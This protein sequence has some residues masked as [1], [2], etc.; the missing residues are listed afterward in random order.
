[1]KVLDNKKEKKILTLKPIIHELLKPV[2]SDD[3]NRTEIKLGFLTHSIYVDLDLDQEEE[4][5]VE[6]AVLALSDMTSDEFYA[7]SSSDYNS[8]KNII[9][10]MITKTSKDHWLSSVAVS[11]EKIQLA[12]PIK[13]DDGHIITELT[14]KIPTVRTR[15][16][17]RQLPTAEAKQTMITCEC[18][19]LSKTEVGRLFLP[20]WSQAQANIN[21]F[22]NKAADFFQTEM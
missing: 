20:D 19:G 2:G 16:I 4:E 9:T 15:K 14:M 22:L 10:S 7:L 21:N 8:L 11:H 1:M 17:Y 18:T 13:S 5:W 3:A 12:M 6:E